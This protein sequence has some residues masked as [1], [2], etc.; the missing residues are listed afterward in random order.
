MARA[1]GPLANG[2]FPVV[3]AAFSSGVRQV[4][5]AAGRCPTAA[6]CAWQEREDAG[7]PSSSSPVPGPPRDHRQS[8]QDGGGRPPIR[9]SGSSLNRS[10]RPAP[11]A[12]PRRR[13]ARGTLGA[14]TAARSPTRPLSSAPQ[15][16]PDTRSSL[17]GAVGAPS[18]T[19]PARRHPLD[20]RP[21]RRA[22]GSA[23]DGP[24]GVSVFGRRPWCE[25][26]PGPRR[27]FAE[28]RGPRGEGPPPQ[29]DDLVIGNR[30]AGPTAA[31]R[32]HPTWRGCPASLKVRSTS[33]RSRGH[34]P[35]VEQ[36]RRP[37][38]RLIG[39]NPT[40]EKIAHGLDQCGWRPP[41]PDAGS[42]HSVRVRQQGPRSRSCRARTGRGR[43][44]DAHRGRSAAAASE[45]NGAGRRRRG[46]P[47]SG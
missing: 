16:G 18:P 39:R 13:R 29:G 4:P 14:L 17:P 26:W 40:V 19:I 45:G 15:A 38:A 44:R 3:A 7:P 5:P 31:R 27:T 22:N 32:G 25:W 43:H 33:P 6:A 37:R 34:E 20:P 8:S 21:R 1:P 9:W 46:G 35:G 24:P 30:S 47:C 36:V 41:G 23:A 28:A 2:V 42:R 10:S 11:Q 12:G